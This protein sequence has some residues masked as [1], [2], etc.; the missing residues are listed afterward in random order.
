MTPAE[1]T[2]RGRPQSSSREMLQ[3]AAFEL[4]L[5]NGYAGTTVSQ[6]ANR[7]G[8]SRNTFFNY[9]SGKSDVFWI[10]LDSTLELLREALRVASKDQPAIEAV[11]DALLG[12][13]DSLGSER[14][15]WALTQFSMIGDTQELQ[16]AATSRLGNHIR[17]ITDFLAPSFLD[18]HAPMLARSAAYATVGACV[19]AAQAWAA[20][21]TSRGELRPYLRSTLA[22]VIDGFRSL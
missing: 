13:A 16:A 8:V 17:V 22:P 4:F 2:T 14:V 21:G 20:A 19:S 6:I 1:I 15:P 12:I 11:K 7:A 5:E 10:D 9:F 18:A 3:E